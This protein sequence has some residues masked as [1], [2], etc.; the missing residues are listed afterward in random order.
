VPAKL[1]L[2]PGEG[3]SRYY[4]LREQGEHSVGRDPACEVVLEDARVSARHARLRFS[5]GSWVLADL[6]SKN[7]TFVNAVRV[8]EGALHDED[9]VSF[10]GLLSRF[11]AVSEEDVEALASE[12]TRRLQTFSEA[13]RILER[14]R[15]PREL[16]KSLL[17]SVLDLAGAERG[18]L[19]LFGSEG[20][21]RAEVVGGF[22]DSGSPKASFNGSLGAIEQTLKTGK[23]VVTANAKADAYLGK[24]RSVLELGIEALACVPLRGDGGVI[25]LIYV[26]GRRRGGTFTDLDLEILEAL[27]DHAAVAA[28]SLRL[29]RQIRELVGLASAEPGAGA[30]FLEEFEGRIREV[31]RRCASS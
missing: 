3:V 11:E 28:G 10:G 25:G 9:W 12:R 22:G 21:V 16:L 13:R 30:L 19:L 31:A 20:E 14:N 2:Y 15:E 1:T 29:D 24:R 6:A 26:D 4:L 7:G 18:F 23:P 8:T 17:N 27:A 5:G